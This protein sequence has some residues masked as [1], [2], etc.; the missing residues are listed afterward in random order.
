MVGGQLAVLVRT[1]WPVA[2]CRTERGH[3]LEITGQRGEILDSRLRGAH[4]CH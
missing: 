3:H 4:P 2:A 1:R